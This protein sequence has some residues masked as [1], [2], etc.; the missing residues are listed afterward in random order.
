MKLTDDMIKAAASRWAVPWELL[1]AITKVESSGNPWAM[2]F[3][4]AYNYLVGAPRIGTTEHAAQK[5]SYGVC[6]VMGAVARELGFKGAYLTELCDPEVG[7]D[8]GAK[9]L[10][11]YFNRY[12]VWEMAVASYNAGAPRRGPSGYLNQGYVDKV[13]TACNELGY[14]L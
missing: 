13:R 14:K 6:Q 10:A 9:H 12:N 5:T 4:P 8:L 2:C 3:E 1:K 11:K 7:L